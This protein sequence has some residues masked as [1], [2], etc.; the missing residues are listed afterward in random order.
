M[1]D[2][3]IGE[4]PAA[5]QLDREWSTMAEVAQRH[6]CSAKTIRR[7]R[8]DGVLKAHCLNPDAPELQRRYRVHRDDERAWIEGKKRRG[9]R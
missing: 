6:G 5:V 4:T 2:L 9:R 1:R 7:L 8:L 3:E